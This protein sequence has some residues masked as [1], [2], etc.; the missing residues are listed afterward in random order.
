[1]VLAGVEGGD[2][3]TVALHLSGVEL[4]QGGA[5]L[6]EEPTLDKTTLAQRLVTCQVLHTVART[7]GLTETTG[8][9]QGLQLMQGHLSWTVWVPETTEGKQ[10]N[11]TLLLLRPCQLLRYCIAC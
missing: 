11:M 3:A 5:W 7:T 2:Q 6:G 1:M 4:R 9:Q 10:G 8:I